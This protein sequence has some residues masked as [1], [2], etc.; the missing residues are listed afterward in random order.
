[1]EICITRFNNKTFNENME[2]KKKNNFTGCIYGTPIKISEKIL[3]ETSVIILEMNNSINKIEGIG[4]IK[5]KLEKENKKKY[6]IYDDNNYNRFIYK[7]NR[8]IDKSSFNEHERLVINCLEDL[9]FKSSKHCKRGQG[10][11]KLPNY[12]K[13]IREFDFH[14]FLTDLYTKRFISVKTSYK[15]IIR[16][17][18]NKQ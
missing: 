7:S 12:I 9:L 13:D 14:K 5:N 2:W 11:Q 15:I 3:P 10:I 16:E 1:M 18:L 6:K 4:I 17:N 8:R